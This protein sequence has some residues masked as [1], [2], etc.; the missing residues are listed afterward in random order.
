MSKILTIS[1]AGVN[2]EI[3]CNGQELL[4]ICDS[5][6]TVSDDP[7]IVIRFSQADLDT[8]YDSIVGNDPFYMKTY[9]G[10][11]TTRVYDGIESLAVERKIADIIPNYH[12]FLMHG[13]VVALDGHAYMFSAPSGVGKTT[14]TRLWLEEYPTSFV[15][16]GDKPFIKVEEDRIFACGTPWAGKEGWNTNTMIPLHAIFLLERAEIDSLEEISLGKAFPFI[17]QQIH[18][19]VDCE[20]MRKTLD[21]LQALQGKVKFYRFCSTPTA[22]AV[23]LAYETAKP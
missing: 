22:E 16:N 9:D 11:T 7:E 18:H 14:R 23:R 3:E 10:V 6:L 15:V 19:P 8:E 13:S 20:A 17:F 1:L 4:Q 21:M 5:Y 2:I 12:A